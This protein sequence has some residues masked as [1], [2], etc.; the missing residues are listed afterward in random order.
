VRINKD[1]LVISVE[2]ELGSGGQIVAEEIAGLLGIPCMG[3]EIVDKAAELSHISKKLLHRYEEKSVRHAYDLTARDESELYIPP[4]QDFLTAQIAACRAL[5]EQGPC[6]LLDHHANTALSDNQDHISIFIHADREK[7]LAAFAAVHG[8]SQEQA[9]KVFTETERE[10]RHY[11]QVLSR[12]WG[13][14]SNYDLTVNASTA[15]PHTLALQVISYLE[16]VT[17]E[18]LVRPTQA[19]KRGA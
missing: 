4:A 5:A 11:Y 13:E 3:E 18:T 14:A 16:T 9:K 1:N 19:L 15:D 17:R 8:L 7:R 10:R 12:H 2:S 6:I